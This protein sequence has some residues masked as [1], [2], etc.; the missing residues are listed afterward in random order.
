MII[1][2][3]S[4]AYGTPELLHNI[5]QKM[6]GAG[7][8]VIT[9]VCAPVHCSFKRSAET[10]L[11]SQTL[12]ELFEFEVVNELSA[13]SFLRRSRSHQGYLRNPSTAYWY[14]SEHPADIWLFNR[15]I[16]R[17]WRTA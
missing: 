3:V 6:G 11:L 4:A 12:D 10:H 2:Y 7:S 13:V 8:R 9:I 1:Q 15:K 16:S 5:L 14:S 17:F